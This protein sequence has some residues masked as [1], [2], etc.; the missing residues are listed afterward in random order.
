MQLSHLTCKIVEKL[1]AFVEK[2]RVTSSHRYFTYIYTKNVTPGD[3]TP[4]SHL[5]SEMPRSKIPKLNS[6]R[7]KLVDEDIKRADIHNRKH[8]ILTMTIVGQT[9]YACGKLRNFRALVRNSRNWLMF[10]RQIFSNDS[11]IRV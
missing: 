9:N 5:K 4:G 11:T 3:K 2:K 8:D 7:Q 10:L 1:H 6:T